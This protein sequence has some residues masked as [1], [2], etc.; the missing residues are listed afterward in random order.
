MGA[1]GLYFKEQ[2]SDES[3]TITGDPLTSKH[4]LTLPPKTQLVAHTHFG[5]DKLGDYLWNL[6]SRHKPARLPKG[7]AHRRMCA[8][9]N[10]AQIMPTAHD[11]VTAAVNFTIVMGDKPYLVQEHHRKLGA[12]TGRKKTPV[13]TKFDYLEKNPIQKQ[14][15]PRPTRDI[16]FEK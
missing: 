16:K 5:D 1:P 14:N 8:V 10:R 11:H 6:S 12:L 7:N 15:I 2:V 13:R 4:I 3:G 9:T